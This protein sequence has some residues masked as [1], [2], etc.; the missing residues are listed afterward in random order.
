LIKKKRVQGGLVSGIRDR[1]DLRI[2]R[3][4]ITRVKN[5]KAV[6]TGVRYK[7]EGRNGVPRRDT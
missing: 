5:K 1:A 2:K 7:R 4:G 3:A 6:R